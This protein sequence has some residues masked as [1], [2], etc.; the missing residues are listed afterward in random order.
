MN[1]AVATAREKS[2]MTHKG[3]LYH[4]RVLLGTLRGQMGIIELAS[5]PPRCRNVSLPP[6]LTRTAPAHTSANP[7]KYAPMEC[8]TIEREMYF[9]MPTPGGSTV[10]SSF[11]LPYLFFLLARRT[12]RDGGGC[13]VIDVKSTLKEKRM[14]EQ[15]VFDLR[16]RQ[17][18]ATGGADK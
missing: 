18:A 9:S 5:M 16:R 11:V 15:P 12:G 6:F 2:G 4:R 17:C 13:V 8:Y 7:L 3:V 14:A 1:V 10:S